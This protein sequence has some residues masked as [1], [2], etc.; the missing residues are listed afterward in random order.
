MNSEGQGEGGVQGAQETSKPSSR[1]I[2]NIRNMDDFY[3]D[4]SV[5]LFKLRK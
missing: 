3:I 2:F 1:S 5:V 4:M